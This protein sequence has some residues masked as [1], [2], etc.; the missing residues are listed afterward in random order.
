MIT[1]K[2]VIAFK[3]VFAW[4]DF[5]IGFYY[6]REKRIL[7]FFPVPMLGFVFTRQFCDCGYPIFTGNG[8]CERWE[9]GCA[10]F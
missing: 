9:S 4:F 1:I 5:W 7:Y 10:P 2:N 6:D 8:W 3:F